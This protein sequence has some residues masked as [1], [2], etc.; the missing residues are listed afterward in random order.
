MARHFIPKTKSVLLASRLLQP[1]ESQAISFEAPK[2]PGIYPYV[3]TYPGHWR[4][5]YGALYVVESLEEYQADANAYLAKNPLPIRDPLLE[6]NT[7][8]HP[9]TFEELVGEVKPLADIG[10]DLQ[11]N[12]QR[13]TLASVDQAAHDLM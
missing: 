7:R 10:N 8:N 13:K 6:L 1:G 4:R 3:C 2:K 12:R 9:W 11:Y 5:M